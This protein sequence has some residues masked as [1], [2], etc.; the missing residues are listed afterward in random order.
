MKLLS[1]VFLSLISFGSMAQSQYLKVAADWEGSISAG[2]QTLKVVFHIKYD[3]E[4]LSAT[5]DSPDQ[6]AFGLKVDEVSFTE[7]VLKM[8]VN[9]AQ[10]S[11]EGT[12]NNNKVEGKWTQGGQSFDLNLEKKKK[13]GTS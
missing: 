10:G 4:T 9:I 13:K 6:N 12:L 1:I 11:Y 3:G 5:M 2:G 8:K 7:G